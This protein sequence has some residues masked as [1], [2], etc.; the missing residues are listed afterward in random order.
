MVHCWPLDWLVLWLSSDLPGEGVSLVGL[1]TYP[2]VRWR[3]YYPFFFFL[4]SLP[5]S[6]F[7][8]FFWLLY[9]EY[10]MFSDEILLIFLF[11]FFA[12]FVYIFFWL[13]LG[14]QTS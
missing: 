2:S 13:D 9:T 3:H 8:P 1:A 7:D 14:G 6:P 10:N 4:K 12:F 11:S 5:L